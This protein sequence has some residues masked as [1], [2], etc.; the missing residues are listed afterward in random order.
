[1]TSEPGTTDESEYAPSASWQ[2]RPVPSIND[3]ARVAADEDSATTTLRELAADKSPKVR[4][5]VARNPSTP[6]DVLDALVR[7]AKFF[8]RFAVAE[9]PS[10]RALGVSLGASDP[11]VRG[12]AARRNDLSAAS[13]Q[14]LLDDPIHTVRERLADVARDPS[15]AAALARDPHPAVRSSIVLN[16]Q[17]C[18]AD[19]EMLAQDPIARVRATAAASRR[20]RPEALTGMAHDRSA[21]VRWSVL[22]NNPERLD[23]ARIIADDSD[24][25]NADQAKSQLQRPRDFTAFLGEIDLVT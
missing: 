19:V 14:L 16:P 12:G 6:P 4:E 9:N 1:M 23:L 10:P 7:D 3:R 8:V 24:Q 17:L 18:A 20:L 22:V 13:V 25:M 21:E 11:D 15:V 2:T 5:A